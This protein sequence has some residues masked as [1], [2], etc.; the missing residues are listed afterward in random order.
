VDPAQLRLTLRFQ[1][2]LRTLRRA[3]GITQEEL[4][5]RAGLSVRHYQLLETAP[6]INPELLTVVALC[7]ALEVEIDMLVVLHDP[8]P[9]KRG[10][11]RP[12]KDS[13]SVS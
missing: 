12:R 7:Q 8:I 4:A 2:A 13:A 1:E 6:Y 9:V 3:Q 5:T 11:G 10:R